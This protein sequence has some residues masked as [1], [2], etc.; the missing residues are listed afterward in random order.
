MCV[1]LFRDSNG[2]YKRFDHESGILR[3]EAL[4]SKG[5][6]TGN[7]LPSFV[8]VTIKQPAADETSRLSPQATTQKR[9]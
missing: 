1:A 7:R 4:L 9:S 6:T 5:T 3:P 2:E 8:A